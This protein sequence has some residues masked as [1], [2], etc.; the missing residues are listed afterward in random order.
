MT[1]SPIFRRLFAYSGH[2][3]QTHSVRNTSRGSASG[4]E[5]LLFHAS[6][7]CS[8]QAASEVFFL[9]PS[10]SLKAAMQGSSP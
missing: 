6:G 8:A 10:L 1:G 9:A 5:R 4:H 2:V 7:I 3:N